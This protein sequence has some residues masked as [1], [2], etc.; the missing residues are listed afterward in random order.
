MKSFLITDFSHKSQELSIREKSVK[1]GRRTPKRI[2]SDN[3]ILCYLVRLLCSAVRKFFFQT[4]KRRRVEGDAGKKEINS[5]INEQN[6]ST[7]EPK[8][9]IICPITDIT[10]YQNYKAKEIEFDRRFRILIKKGGISHTQYILS[11]HYYALGI[12][13]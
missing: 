6:A 11:K 7:D 13:D 1:Y 9:N 3:S 10:F 4:D 8:A 5:L 2:F 12:F